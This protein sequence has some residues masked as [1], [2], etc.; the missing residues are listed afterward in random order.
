MLGADAEEEG[1]MTENI[2]AQQMNAM[3]RMLVLPQTFAEPMQR[4]ASAFWGN[5]DKILDDLQDFA[6]GWFERRH[7]GTQAALEASER[8]AKAESPA[9]FLREYQEWANGALQ[10]VAADCTAC[11]QMMLACGAA[12]QAAASPEGRTAAEPAH[13]QSK[14][15]IRPK[16][17]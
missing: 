3:Q 5:Q 8:M 11:H 13:Q 1:V 7:L 12:A 9:A 16:A 6:N 2:F 17:A 10:R 15:H 4:N 14:T